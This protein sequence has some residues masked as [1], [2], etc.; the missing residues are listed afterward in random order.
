MENLNKCFNSE[1][2][3]NNKNK[4]KKK[5][6]FL[7]IIKVLRLRAKPL[8]IHHRKFNYSYFISFNHRIVFVLVH[9]KRNSRWWFF[10]SGGAVSAYPSSR[11]SGSERFMDMESEANKLNWFKRNFSF[12]SAAWEDGNWTGRPISPATF[13]SVDFV[14]QTQIW[15]TSK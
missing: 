13:Q 15:C 6:I 3:N 8:P 10:R 9:T 14:I 7:I 2:R 12:M 4:K 1:E 5:E 11:T